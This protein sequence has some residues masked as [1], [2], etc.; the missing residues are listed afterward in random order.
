MKKFMFGMVTLVSMT[1]LA[2]SPLD[3]MALK[4]KYQLVKAS[5]EHAEAYHCSKEIEVMVNEEG[6]FLRGTSDNISHASFSS[7]NAGCDSNSGDIGPLR[8]TC[9]NFN[10]KSVSDS[11]TEPVTIVGYV[12]ENKKISLNRKDRLVFSNNVTQ[13]PF[14]IT[15]LWND[16]EFKCEYKRVIAE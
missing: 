5:S 13:I 3:S 11:L 10:R 12:R 2:N 1:A 16:D 14:G 9:T 8:V 6:V 7:S 4:G 15:G